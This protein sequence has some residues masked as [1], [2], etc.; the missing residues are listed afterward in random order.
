MNTPANP[1]FSS[2][3]K[4]IYSNTLHFA[5]ENFQRKNFDIF[6]ISPQII[7][8]GYTFETPR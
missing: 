6:L 1:T 4:H 8:C 3:G 7:N 5:K 2:K